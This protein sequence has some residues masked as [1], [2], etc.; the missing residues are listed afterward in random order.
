MWRVYNL[1][2]TN[3]FTYS[4]ANT[5]LGQSER[6][7]YL[8]YL[9]KVVQLKYTFSQKQSH[10]HISSFQFSH[11]VFKVKHKTMLRNIKY[12]IKYSFDVILYIM[13]QH[14]LRKKTKTWDMQMTLLLTKWVFQLD[15]LFKNSCIK[16]IYHE[17]NWS[18]CSKCNFLIF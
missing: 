9:E 11:I 5:P 6:A 8:M 10:L 14:F 4:H 2:H 1:H 15:N 13:V 3:V 17:K 7:Y 16:K 12:I 18:H